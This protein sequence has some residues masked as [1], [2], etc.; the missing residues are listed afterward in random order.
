MLLGVSRVHESV[1][2]FLV[3]GIKRRLGG[4]CASAASPCSGW[5]S[6]ATPTTSATR[7]RTS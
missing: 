4:S 2:L 1:P 5:R 3:D 6:S 7:C